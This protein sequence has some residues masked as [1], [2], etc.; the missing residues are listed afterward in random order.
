MENTEARE[1]APLVTLS[2]SCLLP[3]LLPLN[4]TLARKGSCVAIPASY[5]L[6]GLALGTD[7]F[8]KSFPSPAPRAMAGGPW[9]PPPH[10]PLCA[11]GAQLQVY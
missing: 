6:H 2:T 10:S 11:A 5:S 3:D 1:W 4:P 8:Q 7:V 9:P